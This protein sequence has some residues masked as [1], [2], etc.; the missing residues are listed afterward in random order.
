MQQNNFKNA[1]PFKL[2]QYLSLL[3]VESWI[4][5]IT[6]GHESVNMFDDTKGIATA[7]IVIDLTAEIIFVCKANK[8]I[9]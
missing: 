3:D 2:S 1:N 5:V 8:E 7:L 4:K 9:K 6:A